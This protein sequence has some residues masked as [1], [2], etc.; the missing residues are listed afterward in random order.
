MR[1]RQKLEGLQILRALAASLVVVDH[2]LYQENRQHWPSPIPAGYAPTIGYLG[3]AAFFVTSGFI[4]ATTTWGSFGP[5]E[6]RLFAIRRAI[7]IVPLY[8][9]ATIAT[10]YDEFRSAGFAGRFVMSLL[11][12][13][14]LNPDGLWQPIVG[15]GWTLDLEVAFYA[16]FAV[17]MV[18]PARAGLTVCLAVLGAVGAAGFVPNLPGALRFYADPLVLLFGIGILIAV[19]RRHERLHFRAW[20]GTGVML[21]IA[22]AVIAVA[23]IERRPHDGSPVW[24][25]VSATAATT[26]V[27]VAVNTPAP[28]PAQVGSALVLAG[29]ASYDTYLFHGFMLVV[30]VNVWRW[31]HLPVALDALVVQVLAALVLVNLGG[32]IIHRLLDPLV[33]R[34]LDR[35]AKRRWG[36][37]AVTTAV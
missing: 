29:D 8:W 32:W 21:L 18:L 23:V 27:L 13:P 7:R 9:L 11:F 36:A 22:A 10:S 33:T 20:H 24:F 19:A 2:L 14:Y 12:I 26:L 4:M 3:V 37:E 1:S 16:L 31:T 5:R 34:P 35:I 28:R 17:C 15:V 25:V 30:L 6:A